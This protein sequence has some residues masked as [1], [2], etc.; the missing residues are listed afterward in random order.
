MKKKRYKLIQKAKELPEK[1]GVYLFKD[2]NKQV[3]YVGK[4]FSLKKRV[5]S[6]FRGSSDNLKT[7]N[8]IEGTKYI[9]YILAQS[10][11]EAL[12]YEAQLIKKY[13]PKYNV[14]LKDDKAYPMIK[15]TVNEVFPRL[16]VAR[17]KKDDAA[18]YFGPYTDA[19][20]LRESLKILRRMFPLRSCR[21]LPQKPCLY[22]HMGQCLAPCLKNCDTGLYNQAVKDLIMF[23]EG[24]HQKLVAKLKKKMYE[25]SQKKD[26]ESAA[27][28][29]NQINALSKI[30]K[31]QKSQVYENLTEGLKNKL[32]LKKA[33]IKI[34]AFDVSN[35]FGDSSVG[36]CVR[37]NNGKPDK[38]N[39]RRFRIKSVKGIDDYAM[40]N[41]IVS[42][43]YRNID[44]KKDLPDLILI[45][46]GR[47]Q[48]N[49]AKK[50]LEILKIKVN[51]ISIAKE[52]E[53]IYFLN[54]KEPLVLP[55]YDNSLKYLQR[56]R[57]EVHR[58][59]ISYH[60]ILRRKL[61][62]NSILKEIKGV[63]PKRYKKI[64]EHYPDIEALKKVSKK[65]L[66]KIPSIDEKTAEEIVNFFA[67][68]N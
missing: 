1:P 53:E 2:I 35:I 21:K 38:K 11:A 23:L 36:A 59:A 37:F 39:Y 66:E 3:I 33:P 27:T 14:L 17:K 8:L 7:S 25:F 28:L 58:F 49:A 65:D 10:E 64:L 30:S 68:V 24:N 15:L 19:G 5:S 63:G 16:L 55:P 62:S 57:D 9:D 41:E 54:R 61:A 45:D 52:N 67:K 22:F 6:Y 18:L 43:R 26:Y 56:I 42:R 46:G 32:N 31:A 40:M 48:L 50:A 47:G 51:L 34:D 13:Q 4:A 29:R 60:R 44:N 12:L 20:L